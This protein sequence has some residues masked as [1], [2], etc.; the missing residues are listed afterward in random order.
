MSIKVIYLQNFRGF[1]EATLELKPLTVLLGPNSSGK[2]S[3]GHAFAAAAHCQKVYAGTQRPSFTP[4]GDSDEWPIDLGTLGDLRTRGQSGR[5][6]IGFQTESGRVNFGFGE[7]GDSERE[8]NNLALSYLS[9]PFNAA[10]SEVV[11]VDPIGKTASGISP[12]LSRV[13]QST[14][15]DETTNNQA[16]VDLDGLLMR[17]MQ[18]IAS[19]T[20]IPPAGAQ[21]RLRFLF[22]TL[23]Y[24]RATRRRPSR[25]Y[26]DKLGKWQQIGYGGEWAPALLHERGNEQISFLHPPP[27]PASVKEAKGHLDQEWKE[28]RGTVIDGVGAWLQQLELAKSVASLRSPRDKSQVQLRVSLPNQEP[29]DITEIGFG[30]SQIL[31]VLTAGLMQPQESL[32][33]VDLP[34]AHLHPLPQARLADFFCSLALSG[35]NVLVE[36]HSEMFFHWLRLRAEMSDQLH[37]KIAV[38]FID[39]PGTD[40]CCRTPR[41][42][43]LTGD[44]QLHWPVGFFEEA[45]NIESRIKIVRDMRSAPQ[46]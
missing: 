27:I 15:W 45:W 44:S 28:W 35:R 43:G 41:M 17:S 20:L 37:A 3:F 2:S 29:H 16:T 22:S 5:V 40:G 13:N 21:E 10:V 34:E 18:H 31:P 46:K 12:G 38:Y 24:L 9:H 19:N 33:V 36:T 8:K 14:W 11:R 4:D 1:R 25:G 39:S 42:V 30:L 26:D 23:T 6:Y 7:F 32:F